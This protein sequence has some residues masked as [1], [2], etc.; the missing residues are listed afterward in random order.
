M[1]R[2]VLPIC[3][4]HNPFS[5]GGEIEAALFFGINISNYPAGGAAV[6]HFAKAG[7]VTLARLARKNGEYHLTVVPA[8]FVNFD[9]EKMQKLGSMTTPQWPVAFAKLHVSADEFIER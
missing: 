7:K 3:I 2:K 5:C 4:I 9:E 1:F 8:E 6:H